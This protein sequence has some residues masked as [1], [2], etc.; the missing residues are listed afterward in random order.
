MILIRLALVFIAIFSFSL[1]LSMPPAKHAA[2]VGF[3]AP[4][5]R[6]WLRAL[7]RGTLEECR[8]DALALASQTTRGTAFLISCRTMNGLVPTGRA[9]P[10]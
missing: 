6:Y 4:D 9:R 5:G 8:A 1:W 2:E 7:P 3:N 10:I